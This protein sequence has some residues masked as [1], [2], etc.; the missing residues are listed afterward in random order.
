MKKKVMI[1]VTVSLLEDGT[2]VT[3]H[4]ADPIVNR[5]AWVTLILGILER[6]KMQM[7]ETI[8][9]KQP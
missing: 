5:V 1:R 9:G 2:V 6:C 7:K 8:T 3:Q 4:T